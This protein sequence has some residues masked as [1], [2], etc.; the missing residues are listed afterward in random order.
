MIEEDS[1]LFYILHIHLHN[2]KLI[3]TTINSGAN[4]EP[5]PVSSKHIEQIKFN[6]NGRVEFRN[7]LKISE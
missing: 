3:V 4:F 2:F 5:L 6:Q 7:T 1:T